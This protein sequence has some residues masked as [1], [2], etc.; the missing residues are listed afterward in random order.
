VKK[1]CLAFFLVISFLN[2]SFAD[3][4]IPVNIK[5]DN[6][7]YSEAAGTVTASGSVEIRLKDFT[8]YSDAL[9]MDTRTEVVTAEG[10]VRMHAAEFDSRSAAL[11]YNVSAETT[12][13][14]GFRTSVTAPGVK[15][16]LYLAADQ[17]SEEKTRWLG[18]E[19]NFT[20][21][22]YAENG[23]PHYLTA[24]KKVEYYPNDRIVSWWN[25][26]YIGPVPCLPVPYLVY[27]L[28][29]KNKRNWTVGHNEVEG[30]FIKTFW[31]YPNGTVYL[32]QMERKGFGHGLD[33]NYDLGK[34]GSGK[35]YLYLLNENDP[36]YLKDRVFKLNHTVALTPNDKF[37]LS[38]S[39][40]YM[41]LVPGGRL[42]QSTYRLE[43]DHQKE[44][45]NLTAFLDGLDNRAGNDQRLSFQLNNSL[46]GYN[47]GYNY[48]LDQSRTEPRFIRISQRLN[49]S[50]PFLFKDS[51]FNL[52][53][54]Y[55]D[56]IQQAGQPGD[57]LLNLNYDIN[58]RGSFYSLRIFENWHM[59]LDRSLYTADSSDQYLEKLPEVT[60]ALNPYDLKLFSLSPTL[61]WGY[62]H[63]VQMV[64]NFGKRDFSSG[65]SSFALNASRSVPLALGSTLSLGYGVTQ[66]LYDPGDALYAQTESYALDTALFNC[67]KNNV[68]FIRGMTEGNTP[69]FFDRLGTRYRNLR[70]TVNL[71]YLDAM[72]WVTTGGYNYETQKYFNID[73]NLALRPAPTL[74]LNF[75]TGWDIENQKYL[76][77]S[78][79]ARYAPDPRFSDNLS[80]LQDLNSGQLKSANNL[81]DLQIA[82]EHDW[83]NHWHFMAGHVYNSFSQEFKLVDLSVV[84]DLHCWEIKY[85]YSDY[86]KEFSFTFTLKAFPDAPVGYAGGKGFYFDSFEKALNQEVQGESPARY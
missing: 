75:V 34:K 40:A 83:G 33:Y 31:D 84:K 26:F 1:L 85:T 9:V 63:E 82:D 47:T 10:N 59:D 61:G 38:H 81:L 45:H 46:N 32:D 11:I 74:S 67:F 41:Y 42:D 6:L 43:L 72:N 39:A 18:K 54:D 13:F 48:T 22:D 66:F 27:D 35:I 24:S 2:I 65:R 55:S 58:Q 51:T 68:T 37:L 25:T 16:N 7:K 78:A 12:S 49:H 80:L 70:E 76:D 17:L 62:Y 15:G 21:C 71:Y 14:R 52:N 56:N 60:L 79:G 4:G 19:G 57:E 53:A 36:P 5:A 64:P 86:R 77:L 3:E 23:H 50:Q 73:T 20:T 28:K 30:T 29:K 69:F 44:G 8:I